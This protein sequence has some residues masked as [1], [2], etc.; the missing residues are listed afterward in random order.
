MAKSS[1]GKKR[2]KQ[3]EK[4]TNPWLFLLEIGFF[5]GLFFGVLRWVCY[6]MNFTLVLP[7]FLA[8]NFFR[9]A[10]LQTGWGIVIGI[11]VYT[12]YS[13]AMAFLYKLALG[14][15]R[16]PWPGILY[17]LVWWVIIFAVVGPLLGISPWMN[18]LGWNSIITELCIST[19][20]GLFIGYSIAFEFTDELSREP[21]AM[22]S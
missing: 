1:S 2:G 17:G 6:E 15:F 3:K 14:K 13:I 7:G 21:M 12:V 9:N 4:N 16:G 18:K 5:A 8:D 20:W 10:F 19:L 11:G 22:K